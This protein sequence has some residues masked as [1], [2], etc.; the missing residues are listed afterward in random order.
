MT[1]FES[2]QC[3]GPR[4]R[5]TRFFPSRCG[6]GGPSLQ[7]PPHSWKTWTLEGGWCCPSA[8]AGVVFLKAGGER[9]LPVIPGLSSFPP[10]GRL[11]LPPDCAAGGQARGQG[12]RLADRWSWVQQGLA[13]VS[14]LGGPGA[15]VLG[16]FLSEPSSWRWAPHKRQRQCDRGSGPVAAAGRNGCFP[17]GGAAGRIRRVLVP[18]P[19]PCRGTRRKERSLCVYLVSGLSRLLRAI[20]R[21]RRR[22]G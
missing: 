8:V 18:G 1:C 19:S 21:V 13:G 7:S 14:H 22:P 20:L 6:G 9:H 3:P 5:G 10:W 12:L 11:G 4:V 15:T 17:F 2:R 16:R